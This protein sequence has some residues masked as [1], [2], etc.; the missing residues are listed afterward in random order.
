[1]GL[2]VS[3]TDGHNAILS[4]S[5]DLKLE[6]STAKKFLGRYVILDG[7]FH[8]PKGPGAEYLNGFLDQT[9]EIQ[10]WEAGD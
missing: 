9:S 7:T 8:A 10:A 2:Y 6:E 3:D 4:N 1:M 5:I